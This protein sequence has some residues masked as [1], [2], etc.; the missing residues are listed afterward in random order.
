MS[1]LLL[2]GGGDAEALVDVDELITC[3]VPLY[4]AATRATLTITD[5][6][7]LYEFADEASQRL[8]RRTGLFVTASQVTTTGGDPEVTLPTRHL[9]T[10]H[11]SADR[12]ADGVFHHLRAAT[13]AELEALDTDWE[14][15]AGDATRWTQDQSG[16]ATLR[17][18][19]TPAS[20]TDLE[21]VHHQHHAALNSGASVWNVPK[22]VG[23]YLTYAVMAEVRDKEHDE[24]MPEVA[25]LARQRAAFLENVFQQYWGRAQ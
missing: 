16:Q 22:P 25:E 15:A 18:Y 5:E 14:T 23:D 20:D 9:S 24:A 1:L 7:E 4:N 6:T 8:A 17:L 3:W 13:A 12:D 2:F 19:Q 10:I 11:V 21:V